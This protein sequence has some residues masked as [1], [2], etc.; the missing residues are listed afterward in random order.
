[1][2]VA[3]YEHLHDTFKM[4]EGDPDS[5]ERQILE[6]Y[7]WFHDFEGDL[8]TL[9]AYIDSQQMLSV[10]ILDESP[11]PFLTEEDDD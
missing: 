7:P 4:Y 1:M 6:D 8:E 9:L 11:H 5:I 2:R 10:E 3:I